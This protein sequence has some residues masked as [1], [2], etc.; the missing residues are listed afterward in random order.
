[1]A[2]DPY[3][4]TSDIPWLNHEWLSE[5]VMYGAYNAAGAPGLIILKLSLSVSY[6]LSAMFE[7]DSQ[8]MVSAHCWNNFSLHPKFLHTIKR[9]YRVR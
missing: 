2:I 9:R 8:L 5:I 6:S 7:V 3:S 4:Y 1:M